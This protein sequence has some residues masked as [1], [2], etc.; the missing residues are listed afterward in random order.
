[1]ANPKVLIASGEEAIR[2]VLESM[3]RAG[4][5]EVRDVASTNEAIWTAAEFAP[6]TLIMGTIMP[7]GVTDEH[8]KK[9]RIDELWAARSI[10]QETKC[11][12]LFLESIH[13]G[14]DEHFEEL[15]REV[16]DCD[17]LP[18]PSEKDELLAI[19]HRRVSGWSIVG[20]RTW[21]TRLKSE[22]RA[23]QESAKITSFGDA[24]L[25]AV[26]VGSAIGVPLFLPVPIV[27]KVLIF[28]LLMLVIGVV[29]QI[30]K[31]NRSR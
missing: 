9:C 10:A 7:G 19:V 6:D 28:F 2:K 8:G 26:L 22:F 27:W 15:R 21:I 4:G 17:I 30:V 11:R 23:G 1:M 24:Q 31:S 5:C 18:I 12:V 16:P 25:R 20:K 29:V 14:L 3:L 13:P